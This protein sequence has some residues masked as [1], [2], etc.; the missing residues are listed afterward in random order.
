MVR[1]EILGAFNPNLANRDCNI[2]KSERVTPGT[3]EAETEAQP[4][5]FHSIHGNPTRSP[6]KFADSPQPP[7]TRTPSKGSALSYGALNS[8]ADKVLVPIFGLGLGFGFGFGRSS[9]EAIAILSK[10][11]DP[12]QL[13][14]ELDQLSVA[15]EE[16]RISMSSV[17][18]QEVFRNKEITLAFVAGGG[19]LSLIQLQEDIKKQLSAE[20]KYTEEELEEYMN[21]NKKLMIRSLWNLNVAD[22]EATLSVRVRAKG[23]R[24]LGQIFQV[25]FLFSD[26]RALVD[27][28]HVSTSIFF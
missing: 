25:S 17:R 18:Y 11:Y 5:H 15:L 23:L 21:G 12:Y 4:P 8:G 3:L 13:K 16:K 26:S 6:P 10:I 19:A 22:I 1:V 9:S 27:V 24:T 2:S 7:T 14:D 28:R 20:G